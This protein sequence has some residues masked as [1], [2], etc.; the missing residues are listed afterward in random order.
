MVVVLERLSVAFDIPQNSAEGE[1]FPLR[2]C[3]TAVL[4]GH[5]PLALSDSIAVEKR[6]GSF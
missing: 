1:N 2:R 5:W 6:L 3:M 4:T